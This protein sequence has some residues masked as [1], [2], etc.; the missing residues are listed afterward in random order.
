VLSSFLMQNT[1]RWL[2]M[3]VCMAI[4]EDCRSALALPD[5][6]LSASLLIAIVSSSPTFP[7]KML[8]YY[9]LVITPLSPW[10]LVFLTRSLDTVTDGAAN[11]FFVNTAAPHEASQRLQES[12]RAET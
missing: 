2:P 6:Y 11:S 12:S 8:V 7:V 9:E 10:P 5:T 1:Y 4:V 3:P